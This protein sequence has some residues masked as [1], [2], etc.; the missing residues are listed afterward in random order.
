MSR[1]IRRPGGIKII[2]VV[3]R[4]ADERASV[5]M[6]PGSDEL[7]RYI[8]ELEEAGTRYRVRKAPAVN[9]YSEHHH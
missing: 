9:G 6:R 7:I 3:G 1:K 8:D 4:G 5:P 2:V